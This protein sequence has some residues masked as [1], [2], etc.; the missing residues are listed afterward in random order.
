ML[1]KVIS[2]KILGSSL[3]K[4]W[5][6][7]F[8]FFVQMSYLS[9]YQVRNECFMYTTSQFHNILTKMRHDSQFKT[10]LHMAYASTEVNVLSRS[11]DTW[12]VFK[13]HF[14]YTCALLKHFFLWHYSNSIKSNWSA[15][16]KDQMFTLNRMRIIWL[17]SMYV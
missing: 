1:E 16:E 8:V 2:W 13:C 11:S 15:L 14:C 5:N 3:R 7:L 10:W 6:F 12:T 17:C 9:E 4:G